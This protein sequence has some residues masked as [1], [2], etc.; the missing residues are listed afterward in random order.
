MLNV[1]V[2]PR[3]GSKPRVQ[4]VSG[5]AASWAIASDIASNGLPD[6]PR[7]EIAS[8]RVEIAK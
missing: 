7:S 2:V 3:D 8:I 6:L 1:I 4:K 5:L